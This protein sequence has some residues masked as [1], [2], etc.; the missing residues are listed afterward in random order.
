M[1]VRVP[2]YSNGLVWN[3]PSKSYMNAERNSE[4]SAMQ[5]TCPS[6]DFLKELYR[7]CE[8]SDWCSHWYVT[9]RNGQ[10]IPCSAQNIDTLQVDFDL[11]GNPREEA[12]SNC[13]DLREDVRAVMKVAR[14]S[15]EV[16]NIL[17]CDD[18]ALCTSNFE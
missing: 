10:S 17:C 13:D 4:P 5:L 9:G 8:A 12:E 6:P 11:P 15:P 3:V 1:Q 16:L 2:G 14:S 7:A 18:R